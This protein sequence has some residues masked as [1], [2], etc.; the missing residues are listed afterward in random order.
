MR[1]FLSLLLII[2]FQTTVL[3]QN[4]F[5]VWSEIGVKGEFTKK[6]KWSA[7]LNTRFQ[8]GKVETFFPQIGFEYKLVKW[9]KPS[10]DYRMVIDK[11]KYGN[12]KLSNRININGEFKKSIKRFTFE[13]RLRYQYSFN[14]VRAEDYDSEFDQAI[15][16]KPEVEYDIKGSIFNPV[17]GAE[18][19]YNPA[20]NPRGFEFSKVRFTVGVKLGLDDPHSVSVK[21]QLDK[22]TDSYSIGARHVLSISYAYKIN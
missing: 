22:K 16:L 21:Y 17:V 14:S 4:E 12:Y 20:Y 6:I 2:G 1:V 10:L 7:E 19:F 18:L 5:A 15:R 13:T 11:N 8:K 3:S 9:F